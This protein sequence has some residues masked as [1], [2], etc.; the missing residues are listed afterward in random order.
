MTR[1]FRL[2]EILKEL[3]PCTGPGQLLQ[4][5]LYVLYLPVSLSAAAEIRSVDARRS[6]C[7]GKKIR[8]KSTKTDTRR[9]I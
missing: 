1:S 6:S 8:K 2:Y 7:P 9:V 3:A 5:T 4:A